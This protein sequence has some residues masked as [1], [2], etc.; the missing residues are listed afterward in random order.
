[1]QLI[2]N[3]YRFFKDK[4]KYDSEAKQ[5]PKDFTYSQRI[6]IAKFKRNLLEQDEK[7]IKK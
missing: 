1:M 5:P 6:F 3:I 4:K 2:V 7:E